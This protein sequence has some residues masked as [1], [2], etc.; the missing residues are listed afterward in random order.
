MTK[1]SSQ[2]QCKIRAHRT[3]YV[4]RAT[5]YAATKFDDLELHPDDFYL[6]YGGQ[7]PKLPHYEVAIM[8]PNEDLIRRYSL[9]AHRSLDGTKVIMAWPWHMQH[10]ETAA[11]AFAVWCVGAVST[12]SG[13]P[14]LQLL[15]ELRHDQRAFLQ[16]MHENY[17]IWI[18]KGP[19]P[20]K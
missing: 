11:R 9:P 20:L 3:D 15:V 2:I 12:M 13:G 18:L 5:L 17:G 16:K 4:Y 10:F 7:R 6:R 1:I 8:I 19:R 14:G